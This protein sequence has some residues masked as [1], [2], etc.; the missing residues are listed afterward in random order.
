MAKKIFVDGLDL[1]TQIKDEPF[2]LRKIGNV[3]KDGKVP[4]LISDR[5]GE[6]SG[7]C[8][9]GVAKQ[10]TDGNVYNITAVIIARQRKPFLCV[11][12]VT[13][14]TEY[15]PVELYGGLSAQKIG[16]Y[17]AEINSMKSMVSHPGFKS[18]LD[19]ALSENILKQLSRTPVTV[20][21]YGTYAGGS[22]A[23]CCVVSRM[24]LSS[25]ASYTKHGNGFTSKEP[26]WQLLLTASLLHTVGRLRFFD[27]ED[28]F[29]RSLLGYNMPYSSIL[30]S[31]LDE[32]IRTHQ[33]ALQEQDYVNLTNVLTCAVDDH[34][35]FK[36]AVKEGSILR[37]MIGL[38]AE[39]DAV[40]YE[41]TNHDASENA[42]ESYFFSPRLN[43]YL[44]NINS[45]P[46]KEA[47]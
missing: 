47:P 15:R 12:K 3:N 14:T 10:I 26:D 38:Y 45:T 27:N 46:N 22:L 4:L 30:Q 18:L 42:G 8:L 19:I 39:C 29:K 16:D 33:I 36:A 43:R 11:K 7:E 2:V 9:E 41:I 34:S 13:A 28:P 21:Y 17:I 37:S 35:S 20:A 23:S 5:S 44:Y 31:M 1:G 6:C 24:V 25:M 40:D 32:F